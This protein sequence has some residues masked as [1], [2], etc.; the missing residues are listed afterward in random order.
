MKHV[1]AIEILLQLD[2]LNNNFHMIH[3]DKGVGFTSVLREEGIGLRS[4]IDRLKKLN[5]SLVIGAVISRGTII[6]CRDCRSEDVM[7]WFFF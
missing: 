4:V 7:F 3:E 6:R 5:E 2:L 1:K